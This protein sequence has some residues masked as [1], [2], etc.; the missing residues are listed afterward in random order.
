MVNNKTS[1]LSKWTYYEVNP[2][3]GLRES[4]AI[5]YLAI[6]ITNIL[7]LVTFRRMR[8][9][10]LQHHLMICL[11]LVDLLTVPS[12]SLNYVIAVVVPFVVLP[13]VVVFVSHTLIL[14][15]IRRSG[16]QRRRR[17]L[18]GMKTVALTVG[19]YYICWIPFSVNSVV[20][21]LFPQSESASSDIPI[22]VA[23]YF[24]ISNS[25]MNFLVYIHSIEQFREQFKGLFCIRNRRRVHCNVPD[26]TKSSDGRTKGAKI[27]TVQ[28][29]DT[30]I[31]KL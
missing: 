3:P 28:P 17:L 8:T 30:R 20:E 12:F 26:R 4:S 22:I 23:V 25:A 7:I 24:V 9:L 16:T 18:K 21:S 5:I 10:T 6:I 1:S 27:T 2:P 31:T 29:C 13:L 15:E 14:R 11:A 19:A